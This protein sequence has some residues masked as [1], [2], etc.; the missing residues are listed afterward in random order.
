MGRGEVQPAVRQRPGRRVKN[1]EVLQV[2]PEGD[3]DDDDFVKHYNMRHLKD[4]DL[5]KVWGGMHNR[6]LESLRA[7]HDR[8]HEIGRPGQYDHTHK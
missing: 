4:I 2:V 8:C 5:G 6:A 7:F 3:M 1:K